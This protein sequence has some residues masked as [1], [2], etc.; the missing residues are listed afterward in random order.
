VTSARSGLS[1]EELREQPDAGGVFRIR[2]GVK[3]LPQHPFGG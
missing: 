3:G 2:P 1:D